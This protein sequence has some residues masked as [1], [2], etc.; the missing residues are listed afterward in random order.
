MYF[1]YQKY[2]CIK[3]NPVCLSVGR[4]GPLAEFLICDADIPDVTVGFMVFPNE[5]PVPDL[6]F[7]LHSHL[8]L[9]TPIHQFSVVLGRKK[10]AELRL[11]KV[12][13]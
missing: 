2:K 1:R 3:N 9:R 5:L 10:K 13:F 7:R 8:I 11:I 4:D 6:M 12:L